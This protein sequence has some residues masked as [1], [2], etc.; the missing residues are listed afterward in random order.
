MT[1]PIR[2]C[3][4]GAGGRM[5]ARILAAVRAEADFTVTGATERPQGPQIGQD[6]GLLAGTERLGVQVAPSLEAALGPAGSPP[7]ADVAID[8]TAPAASLE[9]AAACARRGVSLVVGTTG[10]SAR[11]KEALAVHARTIPLLLAPNM[12][13]GVNVLFRLVAEAARALGS[14]YDCEV[15]ELHHRAKRDAPSGTALR[16]AEVAAGALRLDLAT[17]GVFERH[18]D[19]GARKPDTIGVQTLRGGDVVG[20]HTVFF[21]ADGERLELTHRATSRDNFA[22][23]AVRGARFVAFRAPGMY[24]MQDVLGLG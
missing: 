19:V 20:D 4:C 12:S 18:G 21:L 2:V 22:R 15:V 17:A 9:H 3:V 13:V 5:G 6:L 1:R 11:D 16:L 14:D 10:F 7:L 23:G 24:D 8:F